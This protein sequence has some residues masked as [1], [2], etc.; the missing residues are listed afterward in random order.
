MKD[1]I[2]TLEQSARVL[3]KELI[4]TLEQSAGVLMKELI[5]INRSR[6]SLSDDVIGTL[7]IY[8]VILSYVT[9]VLA[10][11][12]A[13][14]PAVNGGDLCPCGDGE[15]SLLDQINPYVVLFADS[16]RRQIRS[17]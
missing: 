7:A 10:D 13:D 9:G 5:I 1:L 15:D 14:N 11:Y 8:I 16:I 4:I 3:M 12:V 2:I 17:K 6:M